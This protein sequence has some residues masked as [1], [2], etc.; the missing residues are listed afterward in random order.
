VRDGTDLMA[1]DKAILPGWLED[2]G[3]LVYSS[4]NAAFQHMV[5][6]ARLLELCICLFFVF[7]RHF[8]VNVICC[9]APRS[10]SSRIHRLAQAPVPSNPPYM[11]L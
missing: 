2:D 5:W 3:G 9:A 7:D 1:L 6:Y 8:G 4:M 11:T 10:L